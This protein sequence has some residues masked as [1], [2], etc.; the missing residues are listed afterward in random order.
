MAL[1]SYFL[2][3]LLGF[4]AVMVGVSIITFALSHIVPTDPAVSA[5]GDHATDAE[6]N[7]FR[8]KFGLNKPVPQQYWIYVSNLLQG[9]LGTSLRTRRPVAADLH[10]YFPATFELSLTALVFS[11]IIGVPAGVAS[12]TGRNRLPDHVVLVA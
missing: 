12:A 11:I 1:M 5:L 6:I 4:A 7:T 3:R 2:R 10:D 9:D 8:E